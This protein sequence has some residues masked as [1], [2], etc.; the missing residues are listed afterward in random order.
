ML[1]VGDIMTP[2]VH[3]IHRDALVSNVAGILDREHISG[4]PLV[5]NR[6]DIVGII[7]ETDLN[8]LER[9][10]G[11]PYLT[12]ACQ[13]AC[14]D[15]VTLPVSASLRDAAQTILDTQVRNLII[16]DGGNPVG[17]LSVSDLVR[18]VDDQIIKVL[19]SNAS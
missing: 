3:T 10:G 17:I 4:A 15:V 13:L 16:T 18:F 8:N 19:Y 11:D 6:G 2:C 12:Q 14:L 5:D 9:T 1:S 7:T